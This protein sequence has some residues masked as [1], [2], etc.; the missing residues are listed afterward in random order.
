MNRI[1]QRVRYVDL[2][3]GEKLAIVDN[4]IPDDAPTVLREGLARR[5][6]VNT[7]GICPCGAKFKMPT[8][9]LRRKAVR[10]GAV[11]EIT[12]EHESDC[13]AA[14]KSMWSVFEAWTSGGDV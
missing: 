8:R 11:I 4:E 6:I 10:A 14:S 5:A 1:Q 13:P 7:G 3:N 9:A 2:T 12:V